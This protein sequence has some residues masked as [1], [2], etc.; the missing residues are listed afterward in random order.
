MFYCMSCYISRHEFSAGRVQIIPYVKTTGYHIQNTETLHQGWGL[1]QSVSY[2]TTDE[3]GKATSHTGE[4][5]DI[6]DAVAVLLYDPERRTVLFTRQFRIAAVFN[7]HPDG[8]LLEVPAGKIENELSP[9]ETVR[10]EVAE[11]T[12]YRINEITPVL[13]LYMSPGSFTEKLYMF[14][15]PY[16]PSQKK[17]KGGGL[18][19][20]GEAIEVVELP[21]SEALEL[22]R[23]GQIVD[24]KT[25]ILLQ[26]AALEGLMRG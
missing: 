3:K 26:H 4:L 20:E 15:A 10:K 23:S 19:E 25:V 21:F 12:G 2:E 14:T 6:G 5:Y 13:A 17:E 11:E 9:E 22:L 7:G 16:T 1:L 18:E 24:A 8:M